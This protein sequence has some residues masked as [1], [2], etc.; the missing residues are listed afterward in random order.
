[1][2]KSIDK[3]IGIYS[4]SSSNTSSDV[5]GCKGTTEDVTVF[6]GQHQ[7]VSN[8]LITSVVAVSA[9]FLIGYLSGIARTK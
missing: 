5:N 6:S 7:Q 4:K 2:H 9:G 3:E 1:M 8:A